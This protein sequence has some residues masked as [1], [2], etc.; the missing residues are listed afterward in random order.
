D[1]YR[2][3]AEHQGGERWT[4]RSGDVRV[5]VLPPTA[6]LA[7]SNSIVEAAALARASI[8]ALIDV[9][10]AEFDI[11]VVVIENDLSRPER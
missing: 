3:T 8:S 7:E 11:N 6:V 9:P 2:V 4:L 10:E 1:S 5:E